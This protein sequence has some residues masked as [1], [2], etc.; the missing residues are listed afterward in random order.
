[1]LNIVGGTYH[2][3]CI[4]PFWNE[5]FGSGL[6]ATLSLHGKTD[7]LFYTYSDEHT[8]VILTSIASHL[9]FEVIINPI[10]KSIE[11]TYEHPLDNP[12]YYPSKMD[13]INREPIT[14]DTN[15]NVICFG[16]I[17][18]N[19]VIS[20]NKVVYDPQ[21]P[22][23][24]RSFYE[25]GSTAQQLVVVLNRDEANVIFG[26]CD[27][28]ALQNYLKDKK[29][30]YAIVLKSGPDGAYVI[31]D[32]TIHQVPA[33]ITDQVWPIGSG[34]IFSGQFGYNWMTAGYSLEAAAEEASKAT[35]Y[36]V[37]SKALPIPNKLEVRFSPFKKN[38]KQNKKVYLAGP[39]FSMGQRWLVNQFRD[40]LMNVGLAV[41]S[42]FHDVG[43][44]HPEKV[45]PLDL[46]AISE[47]DIILSIVD[48]LDSGT[49]F[50]IGYAKAKGI[51]VIVFVENEK[52]ESLTMLEGTNCI[53]ENDFSTTIYKTLWQAF[54]NQD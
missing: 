53:F 9:G 18:G 30:A 51:P 32:K 11:F 37:N 3:Y 35:A 23:N 38:I 13:F 14:I 31:Q 40:A 44:G 49:L 50:E 47:C 20:G 10:H 15:E 2:E 7:L 1:M 19:A 33:F 8:K 24:A 34:D 46:R 22:G 6:R 21:D 12:I 16:M 28:V 54:R 4:Q 29:E 25:N 5:L 39:F 43:I 26:S 52:K 27:L 48:G 45:A 36:Y 17:E 42:P 41:F